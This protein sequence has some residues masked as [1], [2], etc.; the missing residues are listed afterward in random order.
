L[1][2]ELG[3]GLTRSDFG[4]STSERLYFLLQPAWPASVEGDRLEVMSADEHTEADPARPG[5]SFAG[6]LPNLPDITWEDFERASELA[7]RDLLDGLAGALSTGD[8]EDHVSTAPGADF[9]PGD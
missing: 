2:D 7:Q 4:R 6:S 1:I 3:L 8:D 9:G 5:G